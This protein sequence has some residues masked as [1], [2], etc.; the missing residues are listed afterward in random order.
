M[1]K[2]I[3]ISGVKNSGKTTLI[4]R[5]IPYLRDQGC[6]VA[7]IKHDGHDFEADVKGTDSYC[8]K[9]AGAYATAV[10][11]SHQFMVV[12]EQED[13]ETEEMLRL[14]PEADV[15]LLEGLK[16]SDYP[17]VELIR[18]GVSRVA[19]CSPD[20]VLAYVTDYKQEEGLPWMQN[21]RPCFGF[22]EV[23]DLGKW[24]LNWCQAGAIP[25]DREELL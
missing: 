16:Y 11:S 10:Y 2:I 15:I 6:R 22:E 13:T 17:K 9:Q 19:V 8:H 3:A 20:R 1:R 24:I 25:S 21:G 5:L 7:V 4:T 23:K 12:K 14:F 18:S